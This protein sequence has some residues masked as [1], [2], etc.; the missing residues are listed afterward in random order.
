[1]QIVK[2]VQY[3]HGKSASILSEE[4]QE[5]FFTSTKILNFT[6]FIEISKQAMFCW[7]SIW[8][9]R[10]QILG[11]QGFLE[12]I[13]KK[14]K[15]GELW[16]HSKSRSWL[17]LW[18]IKIC[19]LNTRY[20]NILVIHCIDVDSIWSVCIVGFSI[21]AWDRWNPVG[22][23]FLFFLFVLSSSPIQFTLDIQ[24]KS[25]LIGGCWIIDSP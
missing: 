2:E 9:L 13:K 15:P 6:L 11:W 8:I 24:H 23:L 5:V 19:N 12:T 1:M 21:K 3:C 14:L 7:I 25:D 18:L 20:L 4:L 10:F 16:E 17:I 22:F